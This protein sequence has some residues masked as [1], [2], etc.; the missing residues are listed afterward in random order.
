ML[1]PAIRNDLVELIGANFKTDEIIELGRLIF[2]SFDSRQIDGTNNHISL[3]PRKSAGLLVEYCISRKAIDSLI[4]LVVDLDGGILLGRAI[5]VEGLEIFLSHLAK[6]GL[7]YDFRFRKLIFSTEDPDQLVNWGSL[8]DRKFYDIT[9]MSLDIV[10]NSVLVKKHGIMKM[11]KLYYK[12]WA[13]LKQKLS[14]YEGRMWSWA[15]DGGIMAFAFKD[16]IN[17][18]VLCAVEIQS[19]VPV[20]NL[21][22]HSHMEEDIALRIGLDTGKIKFFSITGQIVSEVINYA[23]HLEKKGTK[24]GQISISRKLRDSIHPRMF[25]IFKPSGVFE[26]R[27]YFSTYKRLDSLPVGDKSRVSAKKRLA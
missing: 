23:A 2:E 27:D 26:D 18:A 10:K 17:R 13:F 11:E 9:V 20:F 1:E 19:T 4:K 5:N 12:L 3:S 25:D 21:A 6:T 14:V 15:G 22:N 8:K 7:I 16:H 24:P